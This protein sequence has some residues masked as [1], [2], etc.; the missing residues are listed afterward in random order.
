M[1]RRKDASARKEREGQRTGCEGKAQRA[2]Y[3]SGFVWI[4]SLKLAALA[5]IRM[6]RKRMRSLST[7]HA[8]LSHSIGRAVNWEALEG[9]IVIP[10]AC[11]EVCSPSP[12]PE[13]MATS[14]VPL[15]DQADSTPRLWSVFPQLILASPRGPASIK[16]AKKC[17]TE[18]ALVP[19]LPGALPPATRLPGSPPFR[20]ESWIRHFAETFPASNR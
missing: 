17:P 8:I 18:A 14:H 13:R 16:R 4:S 6:Q 9:A 11:E 5:A 3:P 1:E 10:L 15:A 7:L 20:L 19:F 2:S 12:S